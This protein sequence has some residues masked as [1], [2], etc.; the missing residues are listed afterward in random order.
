MFAMLNLL[1]LNAVFFLKFLLCLCVYFY[2]VVYYE[3]IC[4]PLFFL[5]KKPVYVGIKTVFEAHHSEK[6]YWNNKVVHICRYL[7]AIHNNIYYDR[8]LLL[9]TYGYLPL[10]I[11]ATTFIITTNISRKEK[12]EGPHQ[13]LLSLIRC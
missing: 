10:I 7:F 2:F 9:I 6:V 1:V 5:M 3:F 13:L 8:E 4:E 12:R 11:F